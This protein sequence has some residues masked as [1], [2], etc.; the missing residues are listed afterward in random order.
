MA[1]RTIVGVDFSGAKADNATGITKALL[2]DDMKLDITDC[3]TITRDA[4]TSFLIEKK[5]DS[6]AV[7]AMDFPFGVPKSF[8]Q[9]EFEFQGTLMQ[10]MWEKVAELVDLPGYIA[11]LRPRLRKEGDL[12]K[13]SKLLRQGDRT[14]FSA[15]YSPLNPASPEMFAMTLYGMKMLHTL[16]SESNF[17]VPP[18]DSNGRSGP[19]L[20]ETMPG[21]L[22]NRFCLPS[23]NYKRKNQSNCGHPEKVRR[24]ILAGLNEQSRVPLQISDA[25]LKKCEDNDNCLDS[26]V[27]AIGAAMWAKDESLFHRPEDHQEPA[28]LDYAKVEGWIY[29]P[30]RI[31]SAPSAP[32]ALNS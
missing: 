22:L 13:F 9:T 25:N 32:S 21:V 23:E 7:I 2:K 14:H 1:E 29:A 16:W 5:N 8:S 12:Q 11:K 30:Q 15:A 18:L 20:L 24:E 17:R 19:V 31:L 28:V 6:N 26:L 4:L 3:Y 27:A 10:E